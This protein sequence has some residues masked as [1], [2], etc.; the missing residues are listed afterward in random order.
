MK[1]T[2]WHI[3]T[4]GSC[5]HGL[6][7]V[8]KRTLGWGGWC[9]IV[10]HG[11]DGNIYRGRVANT[12]NVRMELLAAIE[13]LRAVPGI[14]QPVVLHTDCTTLLIVR[15]WRDSGRVKSY[16]GRDAPLWKGLADQ[17]DRLDVRIDLL[18][19][20]GY[21][22]IHRRAHGIAGAEARGGLRD[23]PPNAVPLEDGH[24]LRTHLRRQTAKQAVEDL[25]ARGLF[26]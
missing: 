16:T 4:D 8:P 5:V 20:G 13:G 26:G 14:R 2:V 22:P 12:T 19:K 6:A 9:A 25:R 18:T 3:W 1:A 7:N 23:L 15:D 10:E 17:F 21:G 24:H 11:A